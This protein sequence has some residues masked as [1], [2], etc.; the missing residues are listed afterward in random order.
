MAGNPRRIDD[1]FFISELKICIS[2]IGYENIGE[3]IVVFLQDGDEIVYSMVIDSYQT[4]QKNQPVINKTI[5][6]LRQNHI[7]RLDTL[8]WSHPHRDHSRGLSRIIKDFCDSETR[9]V[10]PPY[11][12]GSPSDNIDLK[13]AEKQMV[14]AVLDANRY[15]GLK[16]AQV[17]VSC[18]Y[19]PVDEF[20]LK[21]IYG[22]I[23]LNYIKLYAVTPDSTELLKQVGLPVKRNPNDL[24]VS[25]VLQVGSYGFLFAADTTNKHI[26]T[27]KKDILRRCRFVKIPHHAS[28]TA[29]HLLSF[30]P[31]KLDAACTTLYNI[32]R[33]HLPDDD[34][35]RKYKELGVDVYVTGIK[36]QKK[37]RQTY[38][39]MTYNYD[40]SGPWPRIRLDKSCCPIMM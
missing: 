39:M 8:C 5:D 33:S 6:I 14:N 37:K 34:V 22:D 36:D 21:S 25:L 35:V 9:F 40:F 24:S 31:S 29:D 17:Q 7:T 13:E 28:S 16:A 2:V 20:A 26:D 15:K 4:Q 19:T 32:G 11:V 3:S 23:D 10:F 30:L 1:T 18:G 38:R 27:C 12:T